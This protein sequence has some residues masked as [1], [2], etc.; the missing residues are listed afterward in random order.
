MQN[1]LI[2]HAFEVLSGI[3]AAV[4]G[5]LIY[6][7]VLIDLAVPSRPEKPRMRAFFILSGFE[8]LPELMFQ[9][10]H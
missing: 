8:G 4:T 10:E 1:F 3:A 6:G 7:S 5:A 9:G 2:C